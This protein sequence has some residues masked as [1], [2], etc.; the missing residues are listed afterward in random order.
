MR[1]WFFGLRGVRRDSQ[2]LLL[3]FGNKVAYAPEGFCQSLVNEIT[4]FKHPRGD[5]NSGIDGLDCQS[6]IQCDP[7]SD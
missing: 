6:D 5:Q 4:N 2:F 1:F 3:S 7:K